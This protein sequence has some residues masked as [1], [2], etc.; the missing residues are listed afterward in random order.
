MIEAVA[1]VVA[2]YAVLAAA[3]WCVLAPADPTT[4]DA[5]LPAAPVL[6]AAFVAAVC[7]TTTQWWS[8][9]VG[10]LVVGLLLAAVVAVGVRRGQ[11][12]WRVGRRAVVGLLLCPVLTVGGAAVAALPTIWVGDSRPV[13]ATII[14]DQFYFAATSTYLTD[15]PIVPAPYWNPDDWAGSATPSVGP[16]VDVVSNRLRYGQASVS[17]ALS[18]LLHRDPSDTVTPM[19]IMLL[20]LLGSAVFTAASLLGARRGWALLAV[21]LATSSLYVTTQS[22]EGKNDGLLGVSLA[23][24]ALALS[25]AVTRRS[26]YAWPLVV[27]AAGL[28]A[29]YSELVLVLVA[30]IALMTVIGP[31]G[32]LLARLN[33]VGGSWALAA[34]LTPWAWIWL[35]QS[36]RVGD[37]HS[38]GSTPFEGRHGLDL[39]RAAVGVDPDLGVGATALSVV[40]VLCLVVVT[41][42]LVATVVLTPWRGVTLGLVL[43]LGA[44]EYSAI[45]SDAGNLQ[46]RT[47]QLGYPFLLLLAVVGWDTL[48]E[49]RPLR[50]PKM[51]RLPVAITP[52][53]AVSVLAGLAVGNVATAATHLPRERALVQHVPADELAEAASWVRD[54]GVAGGDDVSVV[55][56][57][58]T[59]LIWLA[60]EL[61]D[62]E[63]VDY[64]VVPA[65][66]LGNFP[67]W[68]RRP[69][70]YYLV[71]TGVGLAGEVTVLHRNARYQLVEL[72]ASGQILTPFQPTFYWARPTYMRGLPCAREGAQVLLLRGSSAPGTFTIASRTVRPVAT[73]LRLDLDGSPV[74]RRA[75]PVTEQGWQVQTFQAPRSRSAVLGITPSV[76]A[77]DV[78][79]T[80]LPLVLGD[81][82]VASRSD[83]DQGLT[84]FCLAD[85]AD[86]TDGYDRDL[87]SLT[88]D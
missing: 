6:G 15:E 16:V 2:M 50:L 10:V 65:I 75:D 5:L 81:S 76:A 79:T 13:A 31:R 34:V 26:A 82:T 3:G 87:T 12:P 33:V 60:L 56:P 86:S 42:G 14:V 30:P 18:L 29:V 58:F 88:T 48:A 8:I 69:D 24:V 9:R 17:S 41:V 22:L 11:R 4:R 28:A 40:A 57:R 78:G 80:A 37:R 21:P 71:G 66:Y 62:D 36:A 84:D 39:L 47:A 74:R 67:R 45:T 83:L 7:S 19:S 52:V 55:V 25:C 77:Q 63:G 53:V 32:Q 64:P 46:Y 70:R 72:G 23:L 73:N 43:A 27:A 61:R 1:V 49:R 85:P 54:V 68:D 38:Q 51:L 44:L 20:V 59:D 35:A